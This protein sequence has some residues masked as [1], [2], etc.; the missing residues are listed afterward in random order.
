MV[1]GA[2]K[3]VVYIVAAALILLGGLFLMASFPPHENRLPV[4]L[5]FIAVAIVLLYFSREKK[6]I[7]IRQTVTVS[8]PI[9][10]KAIHCP[11]CGASLDVQKM[12]VVDG[13][14]FMSCEYCGNKFEVTEEPT[15]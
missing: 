3:W 5:A 6:P 14:P 10:V 7:E 15:W 2:S 13:R 8:G 1:R 11:N 9:K 12:M 4:G